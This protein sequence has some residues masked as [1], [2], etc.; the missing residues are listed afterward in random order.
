M[1]P[2]PPPPPFVLPQLFSWI[3][4]CP[5]IGPTDRPSDDRG[6]TVRPPI[7]S[8]CETRSA[9]QVVE[10]PKAKSPLIVAQLEEPQSFYFI[11]LRKLSGN[12]AKRDGRRRRR[13]KGPALPISLLLSIGA[14]DRLRKERRQ[15]STM[16]LTF[17]FSG[18]RTLSSR[19]E[20]IGPSKVRLA[21]FPLP[22][23]DISSPVVPS[24]QC[25]TGNVRADR[26]PPAPPHRVL[27]KVAHPIPTRCR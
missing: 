23:F 3:S 1:L 18:G 12:P 14:P 24:P 5:T 25:Y 7:R 8:S 16:A 20:L 22:T 6:P 9:K 26:A 2:P 21:R 11:Q 10:D 19:T 15:K 4:A 17:P 27:S 13:R